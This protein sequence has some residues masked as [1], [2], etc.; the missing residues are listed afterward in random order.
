MKMW[1]NCNLDI[2][3]QDYFF[4]N[5]SPEYKLTWEATTRPV[6]SMLVEK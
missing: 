6:F 5:E 1:L 2:D 4:V 3:E